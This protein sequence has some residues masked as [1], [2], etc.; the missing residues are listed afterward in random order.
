MKGQIVQRK[1]KGGRVAVGNVSVKKPPS[2]SKRVG[3][4][5]V[6]TKVNS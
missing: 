5:N 6:T 3:S 4:G 2:G 1:S